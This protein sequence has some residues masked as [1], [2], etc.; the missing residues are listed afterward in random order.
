MR[1]LAIR[2]VGAADESGKCIRKEHQLLSN[3][4]IFEPKIPT[5]ALVLHPNQNAQFLR[6][7]RVAPAQGGP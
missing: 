2:R 3:F 5:V 6:A 1:L 4:T 7:L